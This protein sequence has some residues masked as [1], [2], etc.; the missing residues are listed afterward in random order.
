MRV[1]IAVHGFPPTHYAGAERVAE[2]IVK[3]LVAHGHYVEVFTIGSLTAPEFQ[4]ETRQEAGFV[5]HQISYNVKAGDYFRNLYDYP[6]IAETL[7]DILNRGQFDLVHMISGYLLGAQVINT[8]KAAGIPIVVTLTE[9][10]FMCSR[11][12]LLHPNDELCIGPEN[13]AKC[14]RCILEEKRRFRLPAKAAPVLMNIFWSIAHQMPLAEAEQEA[15][16]RRREILQR[17]L[18]AVDL[19]ISPSQFLIKTFT[20]YGFETSHFR[21]VRHGLNLIPAH[22]TAPDPGEPA[23]KP[24]RLGFIGQIKVHKGLDL[25]ID[26]VLPLLDTGANISLDIWGPDKEA[27]DFSRKLKKRT[28]NYPAISWHGRYHL[29]QV[30]EILS[31]FDVLIVPSRWYENSPLVIL[32]AFSAG[33]PVIATNLGGMA[34]MIEH[35][36]S[37][38]LFELNNAAD[39]RAQINRLLLNPDQLQHLRTNIP[40]VKKGETE[41]EEVYAYYV[42]LTQ[43]QHQSEA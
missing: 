40:P 16:A 41:V 8:V 30:G 23:P 7:S 10:W 9:Y 11:L 1:L 32:E 15:I 2:R 33:L 4:L 17:A 42:S 29:A 3:W 39:L 13:D 28:E 21:L 6:L 25:I 36:K 38:L 27:L 5:V 34:E 31:S 24:L 19:V 43:A 12:N 22:R 26:A 37:G 18:D 14:A 35:E 20:Q